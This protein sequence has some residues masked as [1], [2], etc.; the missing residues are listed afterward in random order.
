MESKNEGVLTTETAISQ[1]ALER[2]ILP[3]RRDLIP[4]TL[5]RPARATFLFAAADP[6]D[7]RPAIG[8][9]ARGGR[10]AILHGDGLGIFDDFLRFAFHAV[11]FGHESLLQYVVSDGIRR[12]SMAHDACA[13]AIPRACKGFLQSW[14]ML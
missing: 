13:S 10:L 4:N 2:G 9:D 14:R 11:R 6:E 1:T 7:L 5:C 8:A 12:R 3:G